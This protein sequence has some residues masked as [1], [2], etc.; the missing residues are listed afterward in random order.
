MEEVKG[1]DEADVE[2]EEGGIDLRED[3]LLQGHHALL[4]PVVLR[5]EDAQLSQNLFIEAV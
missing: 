5:R 2:R 3:E 1:S 4:P